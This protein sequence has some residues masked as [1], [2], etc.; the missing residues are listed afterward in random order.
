[1]GGL[2][3]LFDI[4]KYSQ[5]EIVKGKYD[6]AWDDETAF[7][8]NQEKDSAVVEHS[9]SYLEIPQN[10]KCGCE[11][12]RQNSDRWNPAHFGEIPRK[13][14]EEGNLTI[15][16]DDEQEPPE[17][18]DFDSLKE[19]EEAW[20]Q[21]ESKNSHSLTSVPVSESGSLSPGYASNS[22]N[23]S[24][25][26]KLTPTAAKFSITD[27]Q[28]LQTT[29]TSNPSHTKNCTNSPKQLTLLQEALPV[30][31]SHSKESAKPQPMT[32]TC[33]TKSCTSF[34]KSSQNS[35]LLK[36]SPD[37][38]QHPLPQ[39]Q[40]EST[41]T[42]FKAD[43]RKTDITSKNLE[44]EA[45]TLALPLLEKGCFWLPSPSALSWTGKGRPPG[46]TK[47]EARLKELG[48][49]KRTEVLNPDILCEWMGIPQNWLNPLELSPATELL[50]NNE[51]LR[52]MHLTLESLRSPSTESCTSTKASGWLEKYIKNKK[53]KD[54]TIKT[55]P[56]V[57]GI[58]RDPDK[59]NHWYWSYKWEEKSSKAKSANGHITRAVSVPSSKIYTVRYAIS[60]RWPIS[61]TLSFIRSN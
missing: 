50:E 48:L 40:S 32:G 35:Q 46:K 54:G 58:Y 14:D 47:Q 61:K 24:D 25:L 43:S 27:I 22:L 36:T 45:V 9:E 26:Q 53:L 4:E 15:F 30:N 16:W 33:S 57:E 8:Q 21:W 42:T 5:K 11:G 7:P 10:Q 13:C 49:L 18:D 23:L 6:P 38:S 1:M 3:M 12:D 17:P 20:Q 60:Q 51:L 28:E 41:L 52:E 59:P 37:Y 55:Y 39:V 34:E 19:F 29:E 44:L 2:D 56:K 31:L